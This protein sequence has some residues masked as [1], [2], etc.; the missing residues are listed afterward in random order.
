[1]TAVQL[2]PQDTVEQGLALAAAEGA[3]GCVVLVAETSSTNLRWANNTLTTNGAMRGSRV[4]VIATVGSGEGTAAGVVGRSSVTE[5][6][7]REIVSAAIATC[8]R[9]SDA[10]I[11]TS[12]NWSKGDR[13]SEMKSLCECRS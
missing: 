13:R 1:M 6:T 9:I 11:A 10:S 8:M 7:L 3:D 2:T 12:R 4:T 5:D